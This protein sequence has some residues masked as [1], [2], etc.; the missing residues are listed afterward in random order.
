MMR[1]VGAMRT[2]RVVGTTW[3]TW[4]A[5][6][7]RATRTLGRGRASRTIRT[8]TRRGRGELALKAV[9]IAEVP[10]LRGV[11]SLVVLGSEDK[12][13]LLASLLSDKLL[14][15]L[16]DLV[17]PDDN[18]IG[19]LEGTDIVE[20]VECLALDN[21][22]V[23]GMGE[24][25]SLSRDERRTEDLEENVTRG[26]ESADKD[27]GR[28]RVMR[29]FLFLRLENIKRPPGRLL[30]FRV[31]TPSGVLLLAHV[32]FVMAAK[33]LVPVLVI[34]AMEVVLAFPGIRGRA[35]RLVVRREERNNVN[36][37]VNV[38]GD[39]LDNKSLADVEVTT[40]ATSYS[41]SLEFA[42]SEG[43]KLDITALGLDRELANVNILNGWVELKLKVLGRRDGN[44][45]KTFLV[46]RKDEVD[47][48]RR[49]LRR[50]DRESVRVS[51]RHHF[52]PFSLFVGPSRLNKHI[53]SRVLGFLRS[54]GDDNITLTLEVEIK[55]L[56]T[57]KLEWE[58]CVSGE[59]LG[60]IVTLDNPDRLVD[61]SN[62]GKLLRSMV[63]TIT[64]T[65][66]GSILEEGRMTESVKRVVPPLLH[67]KFGGSMMMSV[68]VFAAREA[69]SLV[70]DDK[71]EPNNGKSDKS[72]L[73]LGQASVLVLS[74]LED[75]AGGTNMKALKA[76]GSGMNVARVKLA[77]F[78]NW[79][80]WTFLVRWDA[81]IDRKR[82]HA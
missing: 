5:R 3:T 48:M 13:L 57:A 74:H 18:I 78:D 82:R 54:P 20:T 50:N 79:R 4:T 43:R 81:V 59:N 42:D 29:L 30:F 75:V 73:D 38:T 45:R 77:N 46:G 34:K 64:I 22:N 67:V 25:L 1:A 49:G 32:F 9:S 65:T 27:R 66:R 6:T 70:A 14:Q 68:V 80:Y 21:L 26:G 15:D 76:N 61:S 10:L 72:F 60:S 53:D 17:L 11:L 28:G 41:L 56:A 36:S 2:V 58:R 23:T 12:T 35:I 39:C 71:S 51:S 52:N 69:R 24:S 7:T 44:G 55:V 16:V 37:S 62:R 19:A 33:A 63:F 47:D 8:F 40:D 31:E